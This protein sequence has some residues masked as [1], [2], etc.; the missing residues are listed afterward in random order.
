MKVETLYYGTEALVGEAISNSKRRHENTKCFNCGIIVHLRRDC[1]QGVPRN[2]I[3]SGNGKNRRTQPSD[4]Y[5]KTNTDIGPIN[6]HVSITDQFYPEEN[7][8]Q[9]VYLQC[10]TFSQQ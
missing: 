5:T 8:V 9:V 2:N 3:S 1:R 10:S 6:V 7:K 4:I